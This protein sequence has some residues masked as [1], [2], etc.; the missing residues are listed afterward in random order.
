VEAPGLTRLAEIV[1]E[2]DL[3]DERYFHPEAKG[4]ESILKGWLRLDLPDAELEARGVALFEGLFAVLS[5][6]V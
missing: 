1:H 6:Q 5:S 4:V 3:R 2:I